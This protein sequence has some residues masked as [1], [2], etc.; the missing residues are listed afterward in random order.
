MK[1]H[2]IDWKD[3]VRKVFDRKPLGVKLIGK[4]LARHGA[5]GAYK[6]ACDFDAV[7]LVRHLTRCQHHEGMRRNK[8]DLMSATSRYEYRFANTLV[9]DVWSNV[10]PRSQLTQHLL[11]KVDSL[12]MYGVS[13]D[14]VEAAMVLPQVL[15]D[16]ISIVRSE[17]LP[18]RVACS[19]GGVPPGVRHHI[20]CVGH[21]QV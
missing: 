14:T 3:L 20:H 5:L 16:T 10:I 18:Y 1:Q 9:Y 2:D 13:C 7:G 12:V 15:A 11:S 6:V 21:I 4:E 8:I 19:P 17:Y